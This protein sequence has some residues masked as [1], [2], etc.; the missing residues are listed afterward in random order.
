MPHHEN[1]LLL[2]L[3]RTK[4]CY[5]KTYTRTVW[6]GLQTLEHIQCLQKSTKISKGTLN[7]YVLLF[8]QYNSRLLHKIFVRLV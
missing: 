5:G 3:L 2:P 7:K 8:L 4:D 6:F 1:P